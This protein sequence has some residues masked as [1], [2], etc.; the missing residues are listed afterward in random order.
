VPDYHAHLRS[1]GK[2]REG[3][4]DLARR[5]TVAE[6]ALLQT[7]PSG[8][9]FHGSRSSQYEQVGNAVPPVLASVIGDALT[10]ALAR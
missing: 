1:G 3:T 5:L 7:F 6:C 10:S 9:R 4:L 2:P 8:M